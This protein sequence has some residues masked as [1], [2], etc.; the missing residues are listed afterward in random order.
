MTATLQ[1]EL[2][3][4]AGDAIN[5]ATA[6]VTRPDGAA[7]ATPPLGV[8]IFLYQVT[9]NAAQRN[10]DLPNRSGDG[11]TVRRPRTALDLHF[12]LS[13]YGNEAKLEPQRLLGGITQRLTSR[14]ILTDTMINAMLADLAFDF[15]VGSDL[16]DEDEAVRF[17]PM[18]LSLEELSK[19]W[20][21]FFQTPYAL[22]VAYQAST[23][24]IEGKEAPS[25]GL[26]VR[27]RTI[28]VLP[29]RS[30]TIDEVFSGLGRGLPIQTGSILTI[31][32]R[33]LLGD[34]TRVSIN[35]AEQTPAPDL[36]DTEIKIALPPGCSS[37]INSLQIVHKLMLGSPPAEHRGF[38]SN[39]AAFVVAPKITIVTATATSFKIDIDPPVR[40]SQRATLLLNHVP[41]GASHIFSVAPVTADTSQVDFPV[42]GL[43][44][45][46]DYF[47]RV[48]V[49]GAESSLLD[50]NSA[51]PTFKQFIEPQVTIP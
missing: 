41:S 13:F 42:S 24:F 27:E 31:R 29:F 15:L 1:R 51:S 38:E 26:P 23:V 3:I 50:L 16:A 48:Q 21:V 2:H 19:L 9:P 4:A 43:T 39:V 49:D 33:K 10:S 37:G 36:S 35:G 46:Q 7:A 18:G 8:N 22:S 25:A 47:V 11:V 12:L 30:P 45:G 28:T 32:G 40:I 14:P 44:S 5:G 34:V 17:T 20:S 6:T